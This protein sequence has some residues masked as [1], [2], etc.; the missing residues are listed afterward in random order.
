MRPA[1][2]LGDGLDDDEYVPPGESKF[3]KGLEGKGRE[4]KGPRGKGRWELGE[5]GII[6]F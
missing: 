5:N 1:D 4:G 3:T 2:G 6:L